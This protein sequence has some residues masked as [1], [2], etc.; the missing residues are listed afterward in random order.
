[1]SDGWSIRDRG[2]GAF[3][4]CDLLAIDGVAHAFGLRSHDVGPAGSPEPNHLRARTDLASAAGCGAGPEFTLRQ[5]HGAEVVRARDI[6]PSGRE[7][8]AAWERTVALE[9]RTIGV[10]TADCVPILL[11]ATDGTLV[12][13]VHAGW[14]GTAGR[15][16]ARAV[17][18][19]HRQGC[20]RGS[21]VAAVGPAIGR[22]CYPVSDEVAAEVSRSTGVNV[23]EI[24]TVDPAGPRL[25]LPEANRRQ[26]VESGVHGDAVAV[27]PWCAACDKAFFF[28]FRRDGAAAGRQFSLIGPAVGR[29]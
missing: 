6:P 23:E 2:D 7:A 4:H 10:R 12:A 17:D 28:S 22:C 20:P 11:A 18:A 16:A 21:L 25:D 8:D 9:G 19:L 26:L 24:A 15:I 13:A 5:V 3:A 14:R 27:A 1:M 29:P